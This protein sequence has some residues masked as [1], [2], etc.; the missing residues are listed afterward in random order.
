MEEVTI[1][2]KGGA[3]QDV[4]KSDNIKVFIVDHDCID[5]PEGFERQEW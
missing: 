5:C 3:V 2:I 1:E 4:K